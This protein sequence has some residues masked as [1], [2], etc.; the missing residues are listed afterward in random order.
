[1]AKTGS[2]R[3]RRKRGLIRRTGIVFPAAAI[4]A[5]AVAGVTVAAYLHSVHNNSAGVDQAIDALPN[6]HSIQLLE[7]ERQNLIVMN[8]AARTMS[9]AAKPKVVSPTK[10]MAS[11]SAAAN[12]S[13]SSSG[14]S[15]SSASSNDP[16]NLPAPDPGTAR[17]IGFDMLPQFG[18]SQSTQ[19]SCLDDLWTR[20]SNWIYNAENASGAYGIPQSLP[21]SKMAS[22][23]SDYLTNPSTQIKWGLGY[24]TDIYGTPCG[25]W[26]HEEA[27]GFY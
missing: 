16:V 19:W 10:V 24:I 4:A 11:Q 2:R 22:A 23:G 12:A 20:E 26:N 5:M 17:R 6:S 13:S 27:D 3:S 21:A 9:V 15:N 25:A 8:A 7:A 1:M 14:N 18:F